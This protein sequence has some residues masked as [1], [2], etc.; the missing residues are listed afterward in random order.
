MTSLQF[1]KGTI[2]RRKRAEDLYKEMEH[3]IA[4]DK[5]TLQI[6]NFENF[7]TNKIDQLT[8]KVI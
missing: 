2:D 3:S 7:T 1:G 8:K 5:K 6:V 4:N